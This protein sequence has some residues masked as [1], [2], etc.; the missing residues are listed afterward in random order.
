MICKDIECEVYER[1]DRTCIIRSKQTFGG[2]Y[3]ILNLAGEWECG[4]ILHT[5]DHMTFNSPEMAEAWLAAG[6]LQPVVKK[7]KRLHVPMF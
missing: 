5:Y 2:Y 7:H 1:W 6:C 3:R 4:S